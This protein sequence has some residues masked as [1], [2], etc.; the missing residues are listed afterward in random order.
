MEVSND[1]ARVTHE[2]SVGKINQKELETLMTRGL[3]DEEATDLII[4]AMMR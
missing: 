3:D 2:A 1:E 4:E